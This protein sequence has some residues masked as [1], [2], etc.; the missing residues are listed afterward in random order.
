MEGTKLFDSVKFEKCCSQENICSNDAG[1]IIG[2]VIGGLVVIGIIFSVIYCCMKSKK[3]VENPNNKGQIEI[4]QQEKPVPVQTEQ[5]VADYKDYP[6][7][8]DMQHPVTRD[9]I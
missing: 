1:I 6:N 5:Q 3:V 9:K 7:Y 2:S 4:T 8:E